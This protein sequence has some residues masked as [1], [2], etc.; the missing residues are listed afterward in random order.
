MRAKITF[1]IPHLLLSELLLIFHTRGYKFHN[2]VEPRFIVCI[3]HYFLSLIYINY[4]WYKT[5]IITQVPQ[6]PVVPV[7]YANAL[8]VFYIVEQSMF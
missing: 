2:E 1:G 8:V 7:L 5:L 4:H 3:L 6:V